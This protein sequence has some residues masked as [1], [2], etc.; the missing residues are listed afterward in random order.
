MTITDT[1]ANRG[2]GTAAASRVR[3]YLSAN[4]AL[5]AGDELLAGSRDVPA[6]DA[7]ASSTGSASVTLPSNRA[8][9]FYY[10]L[11]VADADGQVAE[12]SE[13]NNVGAR[14]LQVTN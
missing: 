7:G 14:G 9:G 3:Y 13:T 1:V 11:V 10:L 5:D 6:L 2:A 4:L 12:S 8:P